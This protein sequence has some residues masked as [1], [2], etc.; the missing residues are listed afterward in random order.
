[1]IYIHRLRPELISFTD[2]LAI[3]WYGLAYLGGFLL[4]YWLLKRLI[5]ERLLAMDVPAL[6]D[7]L[8]TFCIFGVMVGGRLGY[9]LFYQP[10][11]FVQDPLQIL[12][13]W[14]GGMASHGGLIGCALV[15]AWWSRKHRV[16]FR[17]LC[18]NLVTVGPLGLGLGR[19]ANFIN[20]EL[21][22]RP[23]G[24]GWGVVFPLERQEFSPGGALAARRYDLDLLQRYVEMGWL[25]PRHPSQ[26]YEA[27]GEGFLLFGCLWFLRHRAWSQRVPGRLALVFLLGYGVARFVVEFFREPDHTVYF[28]WM[29]T[30]QLLTLGMFGT[31][32]LWGWGLRAFPAG[33]TDF[34]QEKTE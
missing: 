7:F 3:R 21:W 1:M 4:G 20:G 23:T 28:G 27:V 8:A 29:S 34:P 17:H 10:E 33:P 26:L 22:G 14:E 11:A 30:G 32:A 9:F 5:R 2:A 25:G 15:M 16:S 12:R 31:A 13:L 6:Q 24:G 18:D 19:L